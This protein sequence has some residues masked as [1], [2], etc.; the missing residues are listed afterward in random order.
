MKGPE[1]VDDRFP[2]FELGYGDSEGQDATYVRSR[3]G[4]LLAR[5]ADGGPVDAGI[6]RRRR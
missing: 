4:I 2:I 5:A 6:L 3:N 1:A